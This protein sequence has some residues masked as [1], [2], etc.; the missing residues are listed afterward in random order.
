MFFVLP[1]CV[2]KLH[3]KRHD[4]SNQLRTTNIYTFELSFEYAKSNFICFFFLHFKKAT[5]Q[6]SENEK[7]NKRAD[8]KLST[9]LFSFFTCSEDN[10]VQWLLRKYHGSNEQRISLNNRYST[11][12]FCKWT[13]YLEHKQT[14]KRTWSCRNFQRSFTAKLDKNRQTSNT[15]YFTFGLLLKQKW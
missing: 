6:K 14:K 11:F 7:W 2:S 8:A 9:R 10:F 13:N 5:L 12:L 4:I 1:Y 3:S 15:W